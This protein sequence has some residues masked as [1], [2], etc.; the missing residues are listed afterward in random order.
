MPGPQVANWPQY[1][2]LRRQGKSKELAARIVNAQA[3]RKPRP[4]KA[5]K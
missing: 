2:A 4:L 1:E 3:K 5:K